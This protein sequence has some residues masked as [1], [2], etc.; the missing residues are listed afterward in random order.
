[1]NQ[2]TGWIQTV[3]GVKF[4][5]LAPREEDLRITDI[6]HALAGKYRFG[7]HAKQRVTIAE[8]SVLVVEILCDLLTLGAIS[9][10]TSSKDRI[11]N[12]LLA[13]I[14]HDASEAYLVDFPRPLKIQPEFAWFREI[15][16]RIQNLIYAAWKVRVEDD[17]L[18]YLKRA[19]EIALGIEALTCMAPL[20]EPQ[21]W[22]WCTKQAI[23][24]LNAGWSMI[25][26][27]PVL[28]KRRYSEAF[29][30]IL[31]GRYEPKGWFASE[32]GRAL[33]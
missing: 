32:Y 29:M 13:G 30:Q 19:D 4:Y 10:I 11:R 28:A 2:S 8:H 7:G 24:Y 9:A 26:Y 25:G 27:D 31:A 1:M 18:R 14:L 23:P 17:T 6:S 16:D 22:E 20:T 12:M 3:S 15:E 5:P 21:E 33:R